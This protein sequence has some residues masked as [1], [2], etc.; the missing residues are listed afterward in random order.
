M[1]R[2]LALALL[3]APLV[4]CSGAPA[5][6]G[7][8]SESALDEGKPRLLAMG[9]SVT[10]GWDPHLE[11]DPHKVQARKYRGY[12]EVLGDE[13][14]LAVDNSSC[15]GESSGS[16][17]DPKAEDNGCRTNRAAY[18]LHTDWGDAADQVDFDTAYLEK[19]VAAG[20]PPELVVMTIGGNDLL[21]MQNHCK[22][23]SLLGGL[24][25]VAKLPFAVHA[26]GDHID[27]ILS[28]IDATGYHGKVALLTTYA[29]DYSDKIATFALGRMNSELREHAQAASA[30]L[31][32]DVRVADGYAAFE[33]RAK[34][35][36]GKTCETGL[37][38]A[39]GDGTCDI[40]PTPAGHEVLAGAIRDAIR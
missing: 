19:A 32:I 26:Y 14:G 2:L 4:A 33:A 27:K 34:E 23:P 20:K 37:L 38:I 1:R 21:I 13:L 9:D 18:R 22:L 31:H 15:P 10:F 3:A 28:A 36:A 35:H 11:A 16:F 24:C 40:H 7:S 25:E 39:N 5:S 12:A 30:K 8:T 6:D 17:L 29:P